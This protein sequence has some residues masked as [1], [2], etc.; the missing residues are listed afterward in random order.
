[1]NIVLITAGGVGKRTC[2]DIPKQFIHIDNKPLIIYTL[3]VFQ[4]CPDIDAIFVTCLDG[5]HNVLWAYSSQY[6]ITKL[7]LVVNGGNT[8]PD[9]IYNGITALREYYSSDDAIVIHDGNRGLISEKII[10]NALAVYFEFGSAVTV[11][12]CQEAVFETMDN[13][14]S[15]KEIQRENVV[16]IQSPQ[17]FSLGRLL[18]AYG[19]A[20]K[21]KIA[22]LMSPCLLLHK[23]GMPVHFSYG[24]ERNIK[25]TTEEDFAIFRSL[26]NT[27]ETAGLKHYDKLSI[28]INTKGY[29][30][31]HTDEQ[32]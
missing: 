2:Q 12:P 14:T 29:C 9:S 3:E 24:S 30:R 1:M 4:R 32:F 27:A 5:W 7:K 23:L 19:E 18:W 13:R 28:A 22:P 8:N 6:N 10:N 26:L 11:I 15:Y 17:I 25:I 31:K 20:Q 21:R 16:R